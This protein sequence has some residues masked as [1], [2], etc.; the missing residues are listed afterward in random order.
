MA[1]GLTEKEIAMIKAVFEKTPEVESVFVYGSRAKNTYKKTS[2]IDLA[3]V[4]KSGSENVLAKLKLDL[5]DLSVIYEIDLTDET[6]MRAGDFKNEYER[7]KKIFYLK[8]W[9]KTTLGNI[10]ILTI[11]RTPPRK[12]EEWFSLSKKD[13][14]WI[15]IKDMANCGVFI[16]KTNEFLTNEAVKKFNIPVIP[17]GTIILSFKMTLGRVAITFEDMLS[18]EAIAHIHVNNNGVNTKYLYY[19]LK[20][21]NYNSLGS[22]SSIVRAVNTKVLKEVVIHL[23]Q[24]IEQ[25]AI[26]EVLN[27]LDDKIELLRKQNETLEKIAQTIFKRWFILNNKL[28]KQRLGDLTQVKRGGSPR[29]IQDYISKTGFRWLKI[30]DASATISPYIFKIKECIKREGLSKTTLLKSGSLVLSNSATPGIPKILAVDT[31][32][33]DGWLHFPKSKFSE[34]YLYLL[35]QVIRPQLIQQGSGSVFTNLKT[36]ILKDYLVPLPTENM[37]KDFDNINKPIFVKILYNSKQIQ[38]LSRLR[39]TLLPKLMSG[40]VKVK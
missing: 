7:T 24:L 23:P 12:E 33:H 17:K 2:D 29:P 39:D 36:D 32:I 19:Y 27:S 18:N 10:S 6:E 11:G 25:K 3:V 38:T 1:Y 28:K 30:S 16:K 15:S 4:L 8:G 21:Y 34:E 9:K 20:N 40:E 22:T 14:K 13:W 37:L 26:A 31:C 5:D 35:F